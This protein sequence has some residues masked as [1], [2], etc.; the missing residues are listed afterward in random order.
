MPLG[1]KR[2]NNDTCNTIC[3]INNGRYTDLCIE[4]HRK[5]SKYDDWCKSNKK[6]IYKESC[7]PDLDLDSLDSNISEN[8]NKEALVSLYTSLN[9]ISLKLKLD[10][11]E[12]KKLINNI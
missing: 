8:V 6:G 1:K 12:F 11:K 4:C 5:T 3:D 10:L 7:I 2:C 9:S